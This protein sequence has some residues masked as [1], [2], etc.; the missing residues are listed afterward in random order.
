[1]PERNSLAIAAPIA[2]TASVAPNTDPIAKPIPPITASPTRTIESELKLHV[3]K[4]L[5][6]LR[7]AYRMP[8]SAASAEAKP[9]AYSF[10]LTT[11]IP[12]A[13]AA[14]SF[15]RTAIN[16]R[17]TRPRRTFATRSAA[18]IRHPSEMNA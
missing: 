4:S 8:P 10:A 16:R 9:N 14:R 7:N 5:D 15:V 2:P 13:A 17:P 18:T 1:M 12:S 11:L 3:E 6:R